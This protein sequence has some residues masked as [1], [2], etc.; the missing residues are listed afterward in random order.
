MSLAY[1]DDT[2]EAEYALLEPDR[3]VQSRQAARAPVRELPR[4]RP[5]PQR[6]QEEAVV[7][8]EARPEARIG[9]ADQ[10]H[11]LLENVERLGRDVVDH[12][13]EL[14]H[15]PRANLFTAEIMDVAELE[16][17]I[18]LDLGHEPPLE[19]DIPLS[20]VQRPRHFRCVS[21]NRARQEQQQQR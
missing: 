13:V 3:S 4:R 9:N 1:A 6:A 11:P 7:H 15:G 8:A 21:A 19:L 17:R 20:A 5:G 2:I 18:A 10:L 14:R 12:V 16:R